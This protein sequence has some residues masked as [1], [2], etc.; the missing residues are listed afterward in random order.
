MCG[1]HQW[2]RI[3]QSTAVFNHGVPS[4][5]VTSPNDMFPLQRKRGKERKQRERKPKRK[6]PAYLLTACPIMFMVDSALLFVTWSAQTT[7]RG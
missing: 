2:L 5:V 7:S 6:P 3:D 4:L 1:G